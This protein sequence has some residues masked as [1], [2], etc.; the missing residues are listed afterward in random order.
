[1]TLRSSLLRLCFREHKL[2]LVLTRY[3]VCGVG[4]TEATEYSVL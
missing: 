3:T 2:T 1:M 4:K